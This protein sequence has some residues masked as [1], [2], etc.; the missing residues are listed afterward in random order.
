MAE[1]YKIKRETLTNIG[2]AIRY[3]TGD[4][5]QIYPED[6]P[7]KIRAISRGIVPSGTINLTT[8]GEF[9]VTR[10]ALANVL[11]EGGEDIVLFELLSD[12]SSI[13]VLPLIK[14]ALDDG[15]IPIILCEDE[16]YYLNFYDGNYTAN[17]F[18]A[19]ED[20]KQKIIILLLGQSDVYHYE[21]QELDIIFD[22]DNI[23]DGASLGETAVQQIAGKGLSTNDYTD[24]D[25]NKL[26]GLSNYDDTAI[27]NRVLTIEEKIPTQASSI[28]Q[29]ADKN[30]VNSSVQTATANFRGN[31]NTWGNIPTDVSLYPL[32]YAGSRVPTTNDYL[33]V[34]NASDLGTEYK[35]TWR[36]KYSGVWL[37]DG[38]NG[39]N[40]EYL[41]N[42]EP[43]TAAQIAALNSNITNEKRIEYDNHLSNAAI[44]VTV[45]DKSDWN[46]KYDKP[47]SGVPKNDLSSD[48]QQS[49]NKADSALQSYT[50]TDPIFSSSPAATI[51]SQDKANWNNKL[52]KTGGVMTGNLT[53]GSSSI[54]TNGYL[55][56]TWLQ[57]TAASELF[58]SNQIA[59]LQNGWVYWMSK[60]SLKEKLGVPTIQYSDVDIG[61][62]ASLAEGTFYFVY[63]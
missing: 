15:K 42:E 31:W 22:I 50:E 40:P 60:A 9:D 21:L 26:A 20:E 43:L 51:T 3:K 36:F 30:F 2:E 54:G 53:I 47:A 38:K 52:D 18:K 5:G 6:M 41:V 19:P 8:N 39:W 12:G 33:V 34:Q 32:D 37:N 46:N 16:Y 61:E 28:N 58:D 59:V 11:V 48:V 35:G 7:D 49:L 14:Q 1:E 29:L 10:Y 63:E 4:R 13:D 57:T 17:F 44:H 62:G 23:R 56:G 25:K 24:A 55:Q 45:Q 27:V